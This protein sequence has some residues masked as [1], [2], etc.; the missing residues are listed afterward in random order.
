[1]KAF[2]RRL[3]LGGGSIVAGVA[4]FSRGGGGGL[5]YVYKIKKRPRYCCD[6]SRNS[7]TS[8]QER[9]TDTNGK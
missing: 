6:R 3:N 2:L 1:M 9:Q 8:L 5:F 7:C 4:W